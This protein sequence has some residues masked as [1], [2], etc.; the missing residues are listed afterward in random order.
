MDC[1][2]FRPSATSAVTSAPRAPT[3]VRT[4]HQEAQL[5]SWSITIT[6]PMGETTAQLQFE[7]TGMDLSGEMTGKGGSGPMEAGR[8][9]GDKLSWNCK[10]QKPMPMTL[11]FKGTR[12]DGEMSGT[13]KFGVFASGT[14]VAIRA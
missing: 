5:D 12:Q 10:I 1:R 8:I 7:Q 13:V 9:D 4:A 11:K 3:Y 2:Y 6:S 14:F